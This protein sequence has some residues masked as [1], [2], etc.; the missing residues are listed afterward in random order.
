MINFRSRLKKG[1]VSEDQK[2]KLV[3]TKSVFFGNYIE[4]FL[5]PNTCLYLV[6]NALG[7]S[8]AIQTAL[9]M[10]LNG[11]LNGKIG[12]NIHILNN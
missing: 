9:K 10:A 12:T 11:L 3:P 5:D 7:I 2:D 6:W 1:G 8:T 4:S